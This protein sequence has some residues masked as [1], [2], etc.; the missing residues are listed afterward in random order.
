MA[1][2]FLPNPGQTL[3]N[4]RP[5]IYSNFVD[6]DTAFQVDHQDYNTT[7]EGMHNRVSLLTQNPVPAQMAGIVQ[8]YSQLSALTA[9]PELV[10]ARQTGSS[11]AAV[12][13]T[14]FTSAGWAN[15]GWTRLPSGI[16]LKWK[17]GINM[18]SLPTVAVNFNDL[19]QF[20]GSPPFT[21]IFSVFN[22]SQCASKYNTV[23]NIQSVDGTGFIYTFQQNGLASAPSGFTI[24]VLAIG[25]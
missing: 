13:I 21:S 14:E 12:Q 11:P 9:Q 19:T 25:I 10:F 15:P 8:L 17:S 16:L 6:I 20:P 4:S 24:G 18:A 7:N 1:L 5:G 22:S 2:I 23:I 3:G